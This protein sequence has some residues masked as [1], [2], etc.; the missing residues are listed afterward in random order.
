RVAPGTVPDYNTDNSLLK[1]LGVLEATSLGADRELYEPASLQYVFPL[2]WLELYGPASPNSDQLDP[3]Q[4]DV[5]TDFQKQN[6]HDFHLGDTR[7][8]RGWA[9]VGD[10]RIPFLQLSY[11]AGPDSSL[12][13]AAG[14]LGDA[15]GCAVS[16]GGGA[17]AT[18][19]APYDEQSARY[20]VE[21]WGRSGDGLRSL[22]DSRGVAALD[23]GVIQ[24]R[25]DLVKGGGVDFD[26]VTVDGADLRAVAPQ[27]AMHPVLPLYVDV[28]WSA[29]TDGG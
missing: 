19:R 12:A 18:L 9:V 7:A 21:L 2:T 24:P 28:R 5:K 23:A 13:Q 1:L 22:V 11:R 8:V 26:R 20:V 15:I 16:I 27:H 3:T 17:T 10:Q 25:P 6:V 14:S 29:G 4:Q